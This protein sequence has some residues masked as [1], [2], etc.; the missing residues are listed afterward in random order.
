YHPTI[1]NVEFLSWLIQISSQPQD[2]V[3]DGFM[4]SGSTA[5]AA[6]LTGRRFLGSE[7]NSGYYNTALKRI[8][9]VT[10]HGTVQS[11]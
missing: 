9:E 4:G 5:A 3:F 10:G 1:K 8:K 11:P 6:I 7:I 2:L